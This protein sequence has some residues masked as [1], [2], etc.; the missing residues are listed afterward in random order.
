MVMFEFIGKKLEHKGKIVDF[1]SHNRNKGGGNHLKL[2]NTR[3]EV[4]LQGRH[5]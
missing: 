2:L 4:T 1:Y 3:R 5:T